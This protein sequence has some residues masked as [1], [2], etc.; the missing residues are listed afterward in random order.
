MED[1][2]QNINRIRDET[3]FCS[4][5]FYLISFFDDS[6]NFGVKQRFGIFVYDKTTFEV[7][8]FVCCYF[9]FVCVELIAKA[10]TTL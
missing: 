3:K 10:L 7:P 5:I 8:L 6:N 1:F 4:R 2:G 9:V